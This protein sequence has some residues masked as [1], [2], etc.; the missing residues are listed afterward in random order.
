[1]ELIDDV[2]F[3][4]L[5]TIRNIRNHFAHSYEH[6]A[7]TDESIRT[8]IMNLETGRV[9][10]ELFEKNPNVY[11]QFDEEGEQAV[12]VAEEQRRIIGACISLAAV[13]EGATRAFEE[14]QKDRYRE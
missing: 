5:N 7:L 2:A 6:A 9:F 12:A 13:I 4:D 3:R 1:M 14:R 11:F 10:E 8:Q